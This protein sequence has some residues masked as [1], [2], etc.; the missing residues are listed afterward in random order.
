MPAYYLEQYFCNLRMLGFMSRF[1]LV[2][3]A[4]EHQQEEQPEWQEETDAL[5]PLDP[6]DP[7]GARCN[8]AARMASDSPM[9][10]VH[11]D[12][13]WGVWYCIDPVY[14]YTIQ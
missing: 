5:Q 7:G 2:P 12:L 4:E 3:Q 13:P 10:T 9:S 1:H 6:L 11:D 8:M 14:I